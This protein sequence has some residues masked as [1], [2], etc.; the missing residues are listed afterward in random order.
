MGSNPTYVPGGLNMVNLL[1]I[2]PSNYFGTKL[3]CPALRHRPETGD[4]AMTLFKIANRDLLPMLSV[5]FVFGAL[6][7][8]AILGLLALP[9][10]PFS[11]AALLP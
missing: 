3:A 10:P 4:L 2:S 11:M 6:G 7:A 1:Q 8:I 5:S 9:A